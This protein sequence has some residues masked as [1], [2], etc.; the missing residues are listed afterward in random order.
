MAD[1][2]K[3]SEKLDANLN[4]IA[5]DYPTLEIDHSRM[6]NCVCLIVNPENL[7]EVMQT[8][9]KWDDIPMNYLNC[10]TGVDQVTHVEV[11]YFL[12]SIPSGDEISV[13]TM[14]SRDNGSLPS[15]TGIWRS[16]E[17]QEREVY[18]FFGV[19]FENHP[20]LKRLLTPEE[21]KGFP[22]L[23][24]Y[25][26]MGDPDDLKAIDA[27]L[28]DGWLEKAEVEKERLASWLEDEKAKRQGSKSESEN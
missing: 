15:V 9:A 24:D 10:I 19:K 25:P 3:I 20:D 27:V 5:Q 6:K 2:A 28:P 23:K 11:V 18:E 1:Q 4:K 16:A 8:I 26:K 13:L 22:L 21:Y 12:T 7:F 14:V 17:Y